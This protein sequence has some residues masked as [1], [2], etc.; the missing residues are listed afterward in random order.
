MSFK[1]QIKNT[2]INRVRGL[3][4]S[5]EGGGEGESADIDCA[6]ILISSPESNVSPRRLI[7]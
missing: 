2:K 4:L 5:T 6:N 1:I 7:I 3:A